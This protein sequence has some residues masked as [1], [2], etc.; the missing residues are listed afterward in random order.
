MSDYGDTNSLVDE[1]HLMDP[2]TD[3]PSCMEAPIAHPGA[4]GFLPP[5]P[6]P[7][8]H[9][10]GGPMMSLL[11]HQ[12][13]ND[14]AAMYNDQISPFRSAAEALNPDL[15]SLHAA[16]AAAAGGLANPSGFMG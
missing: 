7:G 10:P 1:S 11:L 13:M 15:L 3:G 8:M 2:G 5:G 9:P 14:P 4:G 12:G 6:P 16:A